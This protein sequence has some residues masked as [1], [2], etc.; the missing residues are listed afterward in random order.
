MIFQQ[1]CYIYDVFS[2][3]WHFEVKH[4]FQSYCSELEVEFVF[5]PSGSSEH[6]WHIELR[7]PLYYWFCYPGTDTSK[8]PGMSSGKRRIR[9]LEDILYGRTHTNSH[10]STCA[11]TDTYILWHCN[12][13]FQSKQSSSWS[14]SVTKKD[15]EVFLGNWHT[16]TL[17]WC[18]Q[19][20]GWQWLSWISATLNWILS[21]MY[22]THTLIPKFPYETQKKQ[23]DTHVNTDPHQHPTPPPH[24][25]THESAWKLASFLTYTQ[26][27][28]GYS[29]DLAALGLWL[30]LFNKSHTNE[31]CTGAEKNSC[32]CVYFQQ[33]HFHQHIFQGR[34][35]TNWTLTVYLC[36]CMRMHV[37][38]GFQ[39]IPVTF[40]LR[41][42]DVSSDMR[43]RCE[44]G[45]GDSRSTI[46]WK[47]WKCVLDH[48][49]S[50]ALVP[51]NFLSI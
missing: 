4:T 22:R 20:T 44:Y 14:P 3:V 45:E 49:I 19:G 42:F 8:I 5:T 26:H 40:E 28:R 33:I 43:C 25:D 6:I 24:P 9:E 10:T 48:Y 2:N 7:D 23:H 34:P 29:W 37:Y 38:D 15:V 35:L 47:K 12:S 17:A 46:W 50:Y 18:P 51:I 16:H 36:V 32:V 27:S 39:I 1:I 21:L 41:L 31:K 13:K 30:D 11:I